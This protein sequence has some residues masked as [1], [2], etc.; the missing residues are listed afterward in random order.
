MGITIT[1]LD[2]AISESHPKVIIYADAGVG[3]TTLSGTLPGKVLILS[4]EEG[5]RSLKLFPKETRKRVS[6]AKV[7][8][9]DDLR[10][11]Y[12]KIQSGAIETDW[13]VL[14]SISEIAEMALREYKRKDKDP[15][16]SYG[17]TDDDVTDILRSF[18]D[19]ACGVIFLAKEH[20]IK[21]Q[22]GD[23]EIDYYG[24][25][26]P[27]QRLTTNVPHLVDEVWRMIAKGDKRFLITRNDGRSRA[28]SRT[29]LPSVVDVSNGIGEDVL[30]ALASVPT[31]E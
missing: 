13:L 20:V 28:K 3:K 30:A 11:A 23:V 10:D 8:T 25:F 16:Q 22:V 31:E 4:A 12:D 15:R 1:T 5:L 9:T 19:L 6:V 7:E 17:K 21:R 18:R 2:E 27:G 14:D 29:D 24:L 26:L